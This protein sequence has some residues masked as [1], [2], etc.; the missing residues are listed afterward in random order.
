MPGGVGSP[1]KSRGEVGGRCGTGA[2][3]RVALRVGGG[4][5]RELVCGGGGGGGGSSSPGGGPRRGAPRLVRQRGGK[6]SP[7]GGGGVSRHNLLIVGPGEKRL[8]GPAVNRMI[9]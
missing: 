4:G 5:R 1:R 2:G 8:T 7:G 3:R 6:T 9:G